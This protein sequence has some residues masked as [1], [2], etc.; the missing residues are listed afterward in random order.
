[1]ETLV[2]TTT[3]ATKEMMLLLKENKTPT[4][5][6]SNEEKKKKHNK[7]RK[8]YNDAP[9]CKN[10]G[11]NHPSKAED[12]CWVLEKNKDSRP[13]TW[14]S[15]K[16]TRRCAGS[17]IETETWQPGVVQDKLST[18]HTYLEATNYW[19]PLNNDNDDNT[20][21]WNHFGPQRKTRHCTF[22]T[23]SNGRI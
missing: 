16:I 8:K 6:A 5:K 7:K 14:K 1:M 12:E 17:S 18:N 3:K 15:T 4:P 20:K 22:P 9:D 23:Q 2:K 11:K 10:C 21:K 19:T 13:A